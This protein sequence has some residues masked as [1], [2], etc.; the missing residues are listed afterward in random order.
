MGW[1]VLAALKRAQP[2]Q[3]L[4]RVGAFVENAAQAAVTKLEAVGRGHTQSD[5]RRVLH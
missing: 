1:A 4:L 2:A 5:E 3:A